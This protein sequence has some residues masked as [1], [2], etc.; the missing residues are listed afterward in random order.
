[1]I[2]EEWIKSKWP[3]RIRGDDVVL[4][5]MEMRLSRTEVDP[6][7]GELKTVEETIGTQ[8]HCIPITTLANHFRAVI[9]DDTNYPEK[10][11]KLD[12]LKAANVNPDGT[13]KIDPKIW[14]RLLKEALG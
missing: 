1:M 14:D 7:T 2:A 5:E 13:V 10:R 6:A 8:R 3:A 9:E 4:E 11:K 12:G